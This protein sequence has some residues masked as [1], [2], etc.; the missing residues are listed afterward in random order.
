MLEKNIEK[1]KRKNR[2]TWVGYPPRYGKS[3]KE[4]IKS[5]EN[6]YRNSNYDQSEF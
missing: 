5:I 6:K 1:E 4:K 3:K 2:N